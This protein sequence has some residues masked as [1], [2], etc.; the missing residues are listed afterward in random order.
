MHF[1]FICKDRPDGGALRAA[2]REAHLAYLKG[3]GDR[4]VS[5]GP[6][7]SDDGERMTGSLLIVD[8]AD[9]AAAG[10]FATADP[11]AK[12]GLFASVEIHRWKK[13]F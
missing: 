5:A 9:R 2:N 11:Y 13:V 10:A 4:I 1:V 7:Q 8:L 12:A 3:F 6:L